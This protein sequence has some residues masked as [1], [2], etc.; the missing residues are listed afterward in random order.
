MKN[1]SIFKQSNELFTNELMKINEETEE[2]GLSLS[3]LEVKEIIFERDK[4][5]KN[6]GR[7]ELCFD[8]TKEI[9]RKFSTSP[10]INKENYAESII[11][12][13]NLFYIFKMKQR[14]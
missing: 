10:F 9:I 12:L 1:F 5:L 3:P 7:V 13:Q 8:V 6:Y 2:R 14:I 4:S 11:S